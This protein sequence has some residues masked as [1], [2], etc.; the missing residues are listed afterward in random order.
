MK[1][2]LFIAYNQ[3]ADFEIANTLFFVKKVGKYEIETAT[4]L[5]ENVTSLGGLITCPQVK[6]EEVNVRDYDLVLISGRD[7][8]RELLDEQSLVVLLQNAFSL[9][10]PI[11]AICASAALLGKAGLLKRKSFTC[12]PNTVESFQD[13]FLDANYTGELI[14]VSDGLITA[15]GTAFAEFTIA[16][17][18]TLKLW[19]SEHQKENAL[20]FCKGLS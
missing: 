17:G 20:K 15:K 9:K 16:V 10:I 6:I 4:L 19:S 1:K 7:G 5:G 8:I 11:A 12:L 18:D 3:Y 2:I 13:V 14:R